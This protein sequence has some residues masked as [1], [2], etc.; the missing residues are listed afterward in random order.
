MKIELS[1]KNYDIGKRL[2]DII[3]TKVQKLD[4][5]FDS[6]AVAK[7]IC[8]LEN[9]IY[10]LEVTILSKGL[11]YR[12]EATSNENMYENI[13][14]ALPKVERQ[15][16]RNADKL[17]TKLRAGAF[18]DKELVYNTEM[19]V[20]KEVKVVKTKS[21]ELIPLTVDDAILNMEELGH[22]FYIF[23]SKETGKINVMYKRKDGN[24]GLIE[25]INSK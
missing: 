17:K 2:K 10:K 14:M 19:P 22:D 9:N 5:Y 8:K 3:E 13:D 6:D 7:V 11:F 24:L 23:L 18:K 16:V 21:F 4:R 25:V 1:S 12:A 20:R 15:I